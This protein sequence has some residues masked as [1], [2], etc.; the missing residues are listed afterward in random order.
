[1]HPTRI[2]HLVI[3]APTLELGA[4][5]VHQAL[6]ELPE[7]GGEHPRMGTHNLLLRTGESS[8]LEVIAANPSAP[9]PE[10]PRWFE[11]DRL[12]ADARARLTTWVA[13]TKDIHALRAAAPLSIGPVASMSRG[14]LEWLIAFPEDGSLIMDGL[15]PY[16]IQWSSAGHPA[17]R[18]PDRE[19]Y[20]LGLEAIH[21][22]P[23][24]MVRIWDGLKLEDQLIVT[25]GDPR[26]LVAHFVTPHGMRRLS[27]VPDPFSL[28]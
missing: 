16:L 20:L 10:H 3:T 13:R 8:Y 12:K 28:E 23:E 18:L 2:D 22:D 19:L 15:C 5:Y 27:S 1:V 14:D 7:P 9:R 26:R 25:E 6:G 24:D 11:L 4:E 21:P 17:W